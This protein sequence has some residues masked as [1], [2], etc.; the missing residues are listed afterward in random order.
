MLG[1][2]DGPTVADASGLFDASFRRPALIECG[3]NM[4]GRRYL[5]KA[6]DAGDCYRAALFMVEATV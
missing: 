4:H 6:L 3:C 2:R 1:L 5:V